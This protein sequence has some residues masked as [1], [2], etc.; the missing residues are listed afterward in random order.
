MLNIFNIVPRNSVFQNHLHIFIAEYLLSTHCLV[1][2]CYQTFFNTFL[3]LYEIHATPVN[4]KNKIIYIYILRR[5]KLER[6]HKKVLKRE[7]NFYKNVDI[8]LCSKNKLNEN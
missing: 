3:L 2:E 8:D 7:R 6:R 1:T 5:M 4:K